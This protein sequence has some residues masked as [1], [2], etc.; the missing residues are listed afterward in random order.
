MSHPPPIVSDP[1]RVTPDWLTAV[2]RRSGVLPEGRVDSFEAEEVGTGQVGSNVR[3]RLR[4]SG[5]HA[6]APASV[7]GK[8]ASKDPLSRATGVAQGNYLREVRFYQ[9]VAPTVG[10]RTPRCHYAEIEP[11]SAEFAL[12]FEDLAP[13]RQGDQIRGCTRDEAALALAELA[14]LHAPRWNDPSLAGLDWLQQGS[15]ERARLLEAIYKEVW[16]GFV[17]R[18]A[19]RLPPECLALAERLADHLEA[20]ATPRPGPLTVTHGDY[21]LDNMLFGSPEGGAPLAVVDWQTPA[22]GVALGDASYFLGAGLPVDERRKHE[23]ELLREY[24]GALRAA[25]VLDLDWDT[26]F[27]QYRR[28]SFAGVVMAVVASMI[29]GQSERGDAMFTVMAERHA[30]HA[31]DLEAEAVLL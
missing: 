6:G 23:R 22:L 19:E 20:W 12:L 14:K 13:A 31:L 25:G 9:Q 8:F 29:V 7:V 15:P 28:F 16:P 1:D 4:T 3:F 21:R 10:I 17:A 2:L 27:E 18:F 30:T 11:A 24:H 26:C 5:A